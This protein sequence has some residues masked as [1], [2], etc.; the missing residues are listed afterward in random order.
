MI[1]D[2]TT[3]REYLYESGFSLEQYKEEVRKAAIK[4]NPTY[5]DI[6]LYY[7]DEIKDAFNNNT[8]INKITAEICS[9]FDEEFASKE[10]PEDI[11]SFGNDFDDEYT[12]EQLKAFDEYPQ[13]VF[14][15]D[16]KESVGKD[17]I[18]VQCGEPKGDGEYNKHGDWIC[19]DCIDE[20]NY[21]SMDEA[22]ETK[23]E[24]KPDDGISDGESYK[25][26]KLNVF[27]YIDKRID[28]DKVK[29]LGT[30]I[31]DFIKQEYDNGEPS[32]FGVAESIVNYTRINYPTCVKSRIP[33]NLDENFFNFKK[34]HEDDYINKVLKILVKNGIDIE[35]NK[36]EIMEF[37]DDFRQDG[38]HAGET[39]NIAVGYFRYK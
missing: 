21:Y 28:V 32:W 5:R 2:N 24:E 25:D 9:L 26:W 11:D 38:Y 17:P 4:L 10:V 18:C 6:D 35:K 23:K 27:Q 33:F 30:Y 19:S 3:F 12:P 39:A 29:E 15:D 8:P 31:K 34:H 16:L 14:E 1:N 20:Y 7:S 13:D 36:A 22:T 37:I